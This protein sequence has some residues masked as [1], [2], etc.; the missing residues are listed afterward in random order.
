M[1]RLSHWSEAVTLACVELAFELSSLALRAPALALRLLMFVLIIARSVLSNVKLAAVP[2]LI[3]F[4]V[5]QS[6]FFFSHMTL[7]GK[8]FYQV[9]EKHLVL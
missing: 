1:A 4:G 7:F 6:N 8:M 3:S 9:M 5:S 2:E